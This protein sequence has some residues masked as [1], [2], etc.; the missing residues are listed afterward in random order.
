MNTEASAHT[1]QTVG[2]D[3]PWP[4]CVTRT[5]QNTCGGVFSARIL[6]CVSTQTCGKGEPLAPLG[7]FFGSEQACGCWP[8]PRLAAKLGGWGGGWGDALLY[9]LQE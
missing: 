5:S 9:S 3:T 1:A 4:A 6:E 8:G 2:S 7:L